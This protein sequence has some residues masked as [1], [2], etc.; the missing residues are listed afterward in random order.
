MIVLF[1]EK[2]EIKLGVVI[3]TTPGHLFV[4][5]AHGKQQ[6]IKDKSVFL[7]INKN[8][9]NVQ[10]NE[11]IN[12]QKLAGEI[13]INF[14]YESAHELYG[15]GEFN[16][17]ALAKEYYGKDAELEKISILI[18]LRDNPIYFRK[19]SSN[20]FKCA[21]QAQVS[22]ALSGLAK[23]AEQEKKIKYFQEYL[24]KN[25]LPENWQ[26]LW[27]A[28]IFDNANQS[29]ESKALNSFA[30]ANQLA[31]AQVMFN[32]KAFS[33]WEDYH[34]ENFIFN[35]FPDELNLT[36]NDWQETQAQMQ[37]LLM[38]LPKKQNTGVK[39]FSI[40]DQ[41]TDEIDDALS[42]EKIDNG[43]KIGIHIA[44]P[45]LLANISINSEYYQRLKNR[46]STVYFPSSTTLTKIPLMGERVVNNKEDKLD[47]TI[48]H[49][50][51]KNQVS[52]CDYF[53]LDEKFER[54]IISLY[55]NINQE[56]Q[57]D[58]DSINTAIEISLIHNNLRLQ[59]I[60][61]NF[62]KFIEN[63]INNIE[64]NKELENIPNVQE[65]NTLYKVAKKLEDG[66]RENG[67]LIGSNNDDYRFEII[68]DI[69]KISKRSRG[70]AIDT[71]VAEMMI[72]ANSYWAKLLRDNGVP[73][74]YR[75]K[76]AE[77]V[78]F[79]ILAA[80]HKTM[81][82]ECYGWFSSPLRRFVDLCN[83]QQLIAFLNKSA[84]H[85]LPQSP[86]SKNSSQVLEKQNPQTAKIQLLQNNINAQDINDKKIENPLNQIAQQANIL[87]GVYNEFQRKMERYWCLRWLII[88]NRESYVA[89][90]L[91]SPWA[92]FVDIPITAKINSENVKNGDI[93]V[94][95]INI[96][97]YELTLNCSAV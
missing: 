25:S 36:D 43:Y 15:E 64:N 41:N 49:S 81:A 62:N 89:E 97:E 24:E 42:V 17:S 94:K 22:A 34:R 20:N 9:I 57:I 83:Q 86:N 73:M 82:L 28:L 46:I 19:A 8:Q 61:E 59:D 38:S 91:R 66:R 10:D 13:D 87:Q 33:T 14:L 63:G 29:I 18:L 21:E 96:N 72:F 2:S 69:P 31:P 55:F 54:P 26:N 39:I 3:K 65:L 44:A 75:I 30:K 53:S 80:P 84:L 68:N 37:K 32:T 52:W 76:T 67:A 77:K 70:S 27:R 35:D 1:E 5:T 93:K 6:K 56:Y 47:K 74:I 92:S 7:E 40:D 48:H 50:E 16:F 58:K 51:N 23:R 90:V 60:G 95:V 12:A 79:S 11:L 85:Y 88:E 71:L 4:E 78:G 45:A